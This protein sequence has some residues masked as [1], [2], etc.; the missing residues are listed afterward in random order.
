MDFPNPRQEFV[1]LAGSF[2]AGH[3]GMDPGAEVAA[4]GDQ[5]AAQSPYVE[6]FAVG[7]NEREA[8]VGRREVD[9]SGRSF[10]QDLVVSPDLLEFA[11]ESADFSTQLGVCGSE[12]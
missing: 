3:L 10:P 2:L 12:F 9:Q 4:V 7:V 6:P 8:F 1:F 5:Y 11:P